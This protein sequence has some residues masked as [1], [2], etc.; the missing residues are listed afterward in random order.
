VADVDGSDQHDLLPPSWDI[1]IKH[2]WS[3]SSSRL[4]FTRDANRDVHRLGLIG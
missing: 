3:P 2:T 1:A 4:V